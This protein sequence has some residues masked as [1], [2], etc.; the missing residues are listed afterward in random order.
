[1][2]SRIAESL[3]WVGRYI[4]RA[5]DTAR[6]LDVHFHHLLEN[7]SA[8]EERSTAVLFDV[9]GADLPPSERHDTNRAIA[10]LA[11]D[12]DNPSSIAGSLTAARENARGAR[13]AISGEL[14]QTLNS[15]YNELG[16]FSADPSGA[17]PYDFFRFVK[18]HA[19]MVL[20]H[21]DS[22][23]SRD[24][25]YRFF[26]LGRSL[27][28]AD[29]TARLLSAR[30]GEASGSPEWVTTLRSCGAH[31]AY[32]R[33][34]RRAVDASLV[35][36]FLLLDRLFP[37]SVFHAVATAEQA[38]SEL[39]PEGGRHGIESE[40]RRVSGRLRTE[41]EYGQVADLLRDLPERLAG[42]QESCAEMTEAIA[43]RFFR[44]ASAAE[45]TTDSVVR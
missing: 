27:E 33:T 9:M 26:I 28:R 23:M 17:W 30:Y 45:W 42:I 15:G 34:Y 36:E 7:P 1:M 11:F 40:P 4:E 18:D 19:A 25:G 31:E 21:V 37:R 41:L 32:L 44:R 35:I 24:D 13:E 43:K 22:T 10:T 39:D 6:I 16:R 3:F 29:M 38:L 8:D 5:D 14:W 20:G 2:L 12:I